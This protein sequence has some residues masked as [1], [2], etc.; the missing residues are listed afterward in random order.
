MS[1]G[2]SI[3]HAA[4]HGLR[5]R[6]R[7]GRSEF[8][9]WTLL[10]LAWLGLAAFA[11]TQPLGAPRGMIFAAAFIL[12]APTWLCVASRRLHDAGHTAWW[13]AAGM[14]P[15]VGWL[16]LLWWFLAPSVPTLNRH[17]KP[18]PGVFWT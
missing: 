3:K 5:V 4:T 18:P 1:P 17:G 14:I 15:V 12:Y 10:G 2:D 9:W 7:A 16:M 11:E 13:L 8:W 6:G